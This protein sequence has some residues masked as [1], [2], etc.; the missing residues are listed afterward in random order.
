[1]KDLSDLFASTGR[2]TMLGRVNIKNQSKYPHKPANYHKPHSTETL[3]K[4]RLPV[5]TVL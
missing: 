1:M 3:R 5:R 2:N 4:F